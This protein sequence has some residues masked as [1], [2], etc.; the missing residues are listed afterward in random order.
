MSEKVKGVAIVSG[1]LDS[2][3][4]LYDGI[5]NHDWDPLVLSFNYGQ[6][7]NRE[8]EAAATI[9]NVLGVKYEEVD[10]EDYGWLLSIGKSSLVNDNVAVPEGRYD[11]ESMKGT[12]VPNRN[13]V[14]LSMA[15]GACIAIEG[16]FV[17]TAVHAGDHA[18]YPDCRPDFLGKFQAA[19]MSA[20][21]GF[22]HPNFFVEAPFIYKTKT[23]IARLAGEL[24]VPIGLTWSCYKGEDYHCGRCGTCVERLEALHEASVED[25]TIYLDID[26]WRTQV[27]V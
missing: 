13:M 6:R 2:V 4:M 17:A 23:D 1:G 7:H 18:I 14:M 3:T 5:R 26:Y 20:N 11:D 9:C 24:N 16:Q 8:L 25:D 21:E 12:V 10:V 27:N 22:I 15:V 19:V